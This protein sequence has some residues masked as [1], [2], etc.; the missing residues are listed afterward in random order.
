VLEL[1]SLRPP[2]S[3]KPP[4]L[5]ESFIAY[6]DYW[7]AIEAPASMNAEASVLM[8]SENMSLLLG[9]NMAMLWQGSGSLSMIRSSRR[10][11]VFSKKKFSASAMESEYLSVYLLSVSS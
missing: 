3:P 10:N 5:F 9:L 11:L 1:E 2:S 4:V 7:A 6:G 8:D